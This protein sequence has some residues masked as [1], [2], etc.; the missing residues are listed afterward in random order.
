MQ[1]LSPQGLKTESD[2]PVHSESL[3]AT[4]HGHVQRLSPQS[5]KTESDRRHAQRVFK[6][7]ASLAYAEALSSRSKDRV[8]LPQRTTNL[9]VL[10]LAGMCKDSFLRV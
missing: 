9:Q 2:Y 10:H 3:S 1:R 8:R 4:S 5:L 6:C 7:Y